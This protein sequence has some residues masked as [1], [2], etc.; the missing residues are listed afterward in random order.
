[1]VAVAALAVAVAAGCGSSSHQSNPTTSSSS[2]SATSATSAATAGST[3]TTTGGGSTSTTAGGGTTTTMPGSA[4]TVVPNQVDVRNLVKTTVCQAISG[5]WEASGTAANPGSTAVSYLITFRFVNQVGDTVQGQG[6]TTVQVPAA[7]TS[8]W[9][10][11]A[12]FTPPMNQTC[13]KVGVAV[14]S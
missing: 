11:T 12:H 9:T 7:G 2:V 1:M 6:A 10:V 14:A 4:T 13:V 5:G 3:T 8:P